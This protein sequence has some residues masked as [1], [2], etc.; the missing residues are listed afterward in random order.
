MAERLIE[1]METEAGAAGGDIKLPEET[2]NG[3]TVKLTFKD[4]WSKKYLRITSVL[5]VIWF[6]V[7]FGYYG[8]V[9]WTPTLLLGKGFDLVRSFEFTLI[10]CLAQLP[11]YYS[12]A[13]LVERIGRK[14]VLSIYFAGTALSAWLFGHAGTSTEV[15]I[16]GSLL[17]FFALGA[18]GCVYA[19][20]PEVYPTIARG[21]GTG[22]ATAFGRLGAFTAPFIVPIIYK[23][24]GSETGFTYVFI[25]LTAVFA[26]VASVVFVFGKE[27]MG[28]S[29]EE[30]SR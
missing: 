28:K 8:F 22:W 9:L 5:W 4:L 1:K 30:I 6:G 7:N 21:T 3:G 25:L 27:T 19:Y 14:K 12:A 29:L 23:F 11:G 17:Y 18:W 2:G 20:T 13:W 10:M 24:Y 26:V 15:L 16:Y